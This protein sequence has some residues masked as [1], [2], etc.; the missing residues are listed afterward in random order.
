MTS[1]GKNLFRAHREWRDRPA[2]ERYS[3]LKAVHEAVLAR[4]KA[5]VASKVDPSSLRA[6]AQTDPSS[7]ST[8]LM[9]LGPSG[10]PAV[11]SHWAFSQL[12]SYADAP[13]AWFRKLPADMAAFNLSYALQHSV[14]QQLEMVWANGETPNTIR[15]FNTPDYTRLWD[16]V[17]VQWVRKAT[18]DES[19]GWHRPPAKTDNQYPSGYYAGDRNIFLFCVNDTN[20]IDDGKQGLGRGFF[21]WNSEVRQMAFGFEAFLYEFV[22]GNHIVWGTHK[23]FAFK[24]AHLG[25]HMVDKAADKL[26]RALGMYL[27][28]GATQEQRTIDAA[29]RQVLAPNKMGVVELLSSRRV[30]FNLRE[31]EAIVS[32]AE[33]DGDD[34][35]L[36]WSVVNGATA[37]SQTRIRHADE[38]TAWDR[39]AGKLLD[40]VAF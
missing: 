11:P 24:M 14:R 37:L 36:L 39:R 8:E 38:R 12:C 20:R 27:N 19:N 7:G 3:T 10:K 32:Q 23:L 16:E 15:C 29:R 4:R 2:D 34:P 28:A 22:C 30:G 26:R 13:A 17:L 35:T 21:C 31:S 33:T 1:N 25:E 18:N 40:L 6:E 9:V 5:S